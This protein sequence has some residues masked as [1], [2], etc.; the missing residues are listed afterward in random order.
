MKPSRPV[1]RVAA[2]VVPWSTVTAVDQR[3]STGTGKEI[4]TG[5]LGLPMDENANTGLLIGA[6]KVNWLIEAT[7][8]RIDVALGTW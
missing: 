4:V 1:T 7:S 6:S 3:I 2:T 5:L 8:L